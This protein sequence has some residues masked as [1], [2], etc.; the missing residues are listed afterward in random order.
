[1]IKFGIKQTDERIT[2]QAGLSLVVAFFESVKLPELVNGTLPKPGSANGFSPYLYVLS[3]ALMMIGGGEALDHVRK[4]ASDK[5]LLKLLGISRLP[6]PDAL[7]D[8]LRRH[9]KMAYPGM[10]T[11]MKAV[12]QPIL[13]R[14]ER[15]D[16]TLDAD[17]TGIESH[18]DSAKMTYK[19]F[20]GY[21]PMLANLAEIPFFIVDDFREGNVPPQA[22]P[23]SILEEAMAFM[24]KGKRIARLRSDA[25]WYQAAVFNYCEDK[26]IMFSITADQDKA[27]VKEIS[28]ITE[29][30]PL[31]DRDGRRT[32]Q[33]WGETVHA[34][35]KTEKSFRL[36]V[37]RTEKASEYPNQTRLFKEYRYHAIATNNE[38]APAQEA[39]HWHNGRG[40]SENYNKE[41]KLGFGLEHLP[42]SDFEANALYFRIGIL[43]YN[44]IVAMKHLAL[45]DEWQTT[46]IKTLRWVLLNTAG[47]LMRHGRRW[48]LRLANLN[49]A[50]FDW[51]LDVRL[52]CRQLA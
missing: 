1:M 42:C 3:L 48:M 32:D 49:R 39:I 23:L 45:G 52:R 9:F 7:G 28:R 21:M 19:G 10:K 26:G 13:A 36:I 8:W 30:H 27:V 18:K 41:I 38:E 33:E 17:A 40:Q 35:E 20:P 14:E 47:K 37:L 5:C 43:A 11:V 44:M 16:F 6:S 46:T 15:D 51:W 31:Y 24:P 50:A 12:F 34:M 22:K 25:A 29:W 2:S 4:I